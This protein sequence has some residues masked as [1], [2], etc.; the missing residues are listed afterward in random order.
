MDLP[1]EV[2]ILLCC[3]RTRPGERAEARLTALLEGPVDWERTLEL[4]E[5]NRVVPLLHQNL[6]RPRRAGLPEEVAR[7]LAQGYAANLAWN[8]A[9]S[10]SLEELVREF[11][12]RKIAYLSFKGPLLAGSYYGD[13]GL[14]MFWD[15]DLLVRPGDLD[16]AF[17]ALRGLGFEA[18]PDRSPRERAFYERYHFAYYFFRDQQGGDRK[19]RVEIDLHFSCLPRTWSIPIDGEGLWSRSEAVRLGETMVQTLA[20][21]DLL[22]YLAVHGT[23]ESWARLRMVADLAAVLDA[24]PDLDLGALL[25]RAGRQGGRRMLLLGVCL[26]SEWLGAPVPGTL[27]AEARADRTVA[28]IAGRRRRILARGKLQRQDLFSVNSYHRRVLDR[29]LDRFRYLWRTLLTPRA[30]HLQLVR[31]PRFLWSLYPVVKVVH[32]YLYLPLWLLLTRGRGLARR[33][34]RG[35]T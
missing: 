13:P 14:R 35:R 7:S 17:D 30:Q 21:E 19:Q 5:L 33:S 28:A 8:R 6:S 3:G 10:E 32:D 15:L 16:P 1:P 34:V 29:P 25:V 12:G 23:K 9:R 24:R 22:F 31:L 11:D 20:A 4:A 2:E 27:L 26:A 18:E